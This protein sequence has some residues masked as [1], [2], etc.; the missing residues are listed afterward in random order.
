MTSSDTGAQPN[1]EAALDFLERW[2]PGGRWV[3]TAIAPDKKSIQTRSFHERQDAQAWLEQYNGERN[4]YFHVNPT[5]RDLEKK[6]Q[7]EHIAELAWLHID[8]DPRPR[9]AFDE[10]QARALGLLTTK[11]PD[12]IPPP[13]VVIFSGGGYQGFW[14]LKSPVPINGDLEA[15]EDA[16]R[17][18][19]QLELVFGGDNCHNIDRIMRLPG[20]VNLPDKVKIEKGRVPALAQLVSFDE[21]IEYEPA[22]FTKAAIVQSGDSAGFGPQA[23]VEVSGNVQRLDSIDELDRWN[24]SDRVKALC[25]QGN[26]RELEGPKEGDDSRSAWLI[27]ALCQLARAN[28]PDEVMY[29][30]ITDPDFGIS[31]SVLDKGTSA[32]KY[33][34]RQIGRAKEIAS[35]PRLAGLNERFAVIENIGGKCRVVEEVE[36]V[37]MKRSMLTLQSFAD[38]KNRFLNIA[39]PVGM[40]QQ[41]ETKF[42]DQGTWWLKNENRR[43]YHRIVFDPSRGEIPQVYNL[44]KGFAWDA[45][46]GDPSPFLNHLRDN[47][48]RGEEE[49]YK[50]L[51]GWMARTVQ[52]PAQP[53]GVAI[54]LRGAR[55]TGKSFMAKMF[56]KL[57]G[58]HYMQVSNSSHLGR[59]L[60]CTPP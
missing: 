57:F 4:I 26:M 36:D 25:V 30:V 43:Q 44:W 53:G 55:G 15:A 17:Y 13:T 50:Y 51:V 59:Q 31:E 52:Y 42:L 20:T 40:T 16:K 37:I 14:K 48:C 28:V 39:V 47:I 49:H 2:Q 29:S 60:Q 10:E 34:K 18:N 5:T 32:E 58:R 11:L 56:G 54:V 38:F 24:V 22:E 33:A 3:L 45:Q 9:E 27:D 7:R 46:P 21:T 12:G 19:Q 35:D 41:G 1:N 23:P 8:I 6:A